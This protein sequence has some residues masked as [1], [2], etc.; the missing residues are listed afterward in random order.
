MR[1]TVLFFALATFW[2]FSNAFSQLIANNEM[3]AY[4]IGWEE[5]EFI[6]AESNLQFQIN[7]QNGF[8]YSVQDVIISDVISESLDLESFQPLSSSHTYTL[9]INPVTREVTFVFEN[10]NL[11]SMSNDIVGSAGFVLFGLNAETG[12]AHASSIFNHADILFDGIP[13]QTNLIKRTVFDCEDVVPFVL[14]DI[15]ICEGENIQFGNANPYFAEQTWT[16]DG[17]DAAEGPFFQQEFT[18]PGIYEVAMFISNPICEASSNHTVAVKPVPDAWFIRQ[19]VHLVANEGSAYQ[20][21]LNGNKMAGET[22]PTMILS[23][24][25]YYSV[26][27]FNESGC[28][29]I[30]L[31]SFEGT[32]S[33]NDISQNK[34]NVFPNPS[35]GSF[36]IQSDHTIK[37]VYIFDLT[38]RQIFFQ[39]FADLTVKIDLP[40]LNSGTYL[41]NTENISGQ[42]TTQQISV[43]K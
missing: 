17:E 2:P 23:S 37:S 30:S 25:G 26:E 38:G 21:Y 28:S 20:W 36:T 18:E 33:I 8:D 22:G 39:N 41:L 40:F 42:K 10:I 34:V 5:P 7:F 15:W 1:T 27:V 14:T 12:L 11:A 35:N 31:E 16:L 24:N 32:T 29:E 4:P 3:T 19:G 13:V 43:V 9:D 6:A